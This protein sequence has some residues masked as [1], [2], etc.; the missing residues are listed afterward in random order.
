MSK[1]LGIIAAAIGAVALTF[2]QD[3]RAQAQGL[4]NGGSLEWFGTGSNVNTLLVN[5]GN[6]IEGIGGVAEPYSVVQTMVTTKGAGIN[7]GELGPDGTCSTC[8]GT[9]EGDPPQSQLANTIYYVYG[10]SI[11]NG[12]VGSNIYKVVISEFAPSTQGSP[13]TTFTW[14]YFG[15]S[16]GACTNEGGS[17]EYPL[18]FLGSY[19]TDQNANIIPFSR[20]GDVVKFRWPIFDG[21]VQAP[22]NNVIFNNTSGSATGTIA[23]LSPFNGTS[24]IVPQSSSA[25]IVR[26]YGYNTD[27]SAHGVFILD[28]TID[29]LNGANCGSG[30]GGYVYGQD[31]FFFPAGGSSSSWAN[32]GENR[33][34][35]KNQGTFKLG[36]CSL[37]SGKE[38]N[39]YAELL[40][41]VEDV[42]F[43]S[44]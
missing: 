24:Q 2:A 30:D 38:V 25:M 27:T 5:Y 39:V 42:N 20:M 26:L 43:L 11:N 19:V 34:K 29:G 44:F 10:L 9:F 31:E 21:T 40:G 17:S 4:L 35:N 1:M 18:L 33:V 41:Y 28:P 32:I 37:G 8:V 13:G 36:F 3:A 14:C 16:G 12:S 6:V 23:F 7:V 15:T 22:Y